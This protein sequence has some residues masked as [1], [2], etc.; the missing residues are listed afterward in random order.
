MLS[1]YASSLLIGT[2]TSTDLYLALCFTTPAP[3]DSGSTL[4]EVVGGGYSR[5]TLG[6]ANWINGV[7]GGKIY[8]AGF[9]LT[10][11][12]DWG[13]VTSYAICDA[14]TAGN[15]L[16]YG[17]LSTSVNVVSGSKVKVQAGSIIFGVK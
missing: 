1:N 17:Y 2:F 5:V 3:T 14:A 16:D 13:M 7:S 9:V 15:M 8:N 11:S 4:D 12:A 6:S 10:P